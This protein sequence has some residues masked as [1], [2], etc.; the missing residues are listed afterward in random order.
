MALDNNYGFKILGNDVVT[1]NGKFPIFGFDVANAE[2]SFRTTRVVDNS[3]NPY[4]DNSGV[5]VPPDSSLVRGVGQDIKSGYEKVLVTRYKHGY[6]YRPSGYYTITGTFNLTCKAKI[7]QTGS[8]SYYQTWY[9]GDFT[10]EGYRDLNVGGQTDPLY[11]KMN[12]FYPYELGLSPTFY[13]L[14]VTYGVDASLSP[15]IVIP[16]GTAGNPFSGMGLGSVLDSDGIGAYVS[17]EVDSTYVSIYM[18][19]AWYDTV[20]RRV[21]WSSGSINPSL[22]DVRNRIRM[23]SNTTGSVFNVTVYLTPHKLEEMILNG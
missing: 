10:R 7:E 21:Y 16:G 9:G 2:N 4:K 18:N 12:S 22:Y 6:D 23:V 8:G 5:I 14:M 19:Y 11:P 20:L 1:L 13:M 3:D 17:V 15:D